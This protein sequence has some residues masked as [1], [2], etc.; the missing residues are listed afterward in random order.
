MCGSHG[1]CTRPVRL[2][3]MWTC[4]FWVIP[5]SATPHSTPSSLRLS[6][7]SDICVR[8]VLARSNLLRR[9]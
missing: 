5:N 4:L 7:Y 2:C 1:L 8:H 6:H 3:S 9:N